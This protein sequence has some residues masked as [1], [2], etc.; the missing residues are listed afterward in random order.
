MD[1]SGQ[2][3]TFKTS[4]FNAFRH[5]CGERLV[6]G[7]P[8]DVLEVSIATGEDFGRCYQSRFPIELTQ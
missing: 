4:L 5:F 1:R 8:H 3:E 6:P 7:Q 2:F